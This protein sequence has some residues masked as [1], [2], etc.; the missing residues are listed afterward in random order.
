MEKLATSV[1]TPRV[2]AVTAEPHILDSLVTLLPPDSRPNLTHEQLEWQ[3][4]DP[5]H[6]LAALYHTCFEQHWELS[7]IRV[8]KPSLR[9]AYASLV[10]AEDSSLTTKDERR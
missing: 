3:T 10:E 6:D 7:D 4:Y 2:S 5:A 8:E 9:A 1:L